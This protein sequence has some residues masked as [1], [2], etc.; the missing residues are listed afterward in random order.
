[1]IDCYGE[2]LAS[3]EVVCEH[4]TVSPTNQISTPAHEVQ[5]KDGL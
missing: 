2:L 3:M 4:L 5:S 1:M